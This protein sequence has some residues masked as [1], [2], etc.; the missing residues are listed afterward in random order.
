VEN[1]G[2]R[3]AEGWLAK[4][5]PLYR[6]EDRKGGFP[7]LKHQQVDE[8]KAITEDEQDTAQDLEGVACIHTTPRFLARW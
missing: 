8:A 5:T 3:A 6:S 1:I 4:E 7:C 2:Q